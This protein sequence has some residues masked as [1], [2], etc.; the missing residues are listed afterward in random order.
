[1]IGLRARGWL[2]GGADAFLDNCVCVLVPCPALPCRASLPC[3][4]LP[5]S[6]LPHLPG[7]AHLFAPAPLLPRRR[8]HCAPH[9]GARSAPRSASAWHTYFF[10]SA[11]AEPL[12]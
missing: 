10:A 12:L 7:A 2:L 9:W 6:A 11:C 3:P 4:A 1:M 8:Q 5:C